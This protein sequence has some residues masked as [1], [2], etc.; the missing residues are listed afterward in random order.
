M[1]SLI[2]GTVD[3]GDGVPVSIKCCL[4]ISSPRWIIDIFHL[5]HRGDKLFLST[6]WMKKND[7]CGVIPFNKYIIIYL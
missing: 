2:K 1:A 4:N 3:I 5:L 7:N 6:L